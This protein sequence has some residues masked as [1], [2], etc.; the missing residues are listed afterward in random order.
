MNCVKCVNSFFLLKSV[1]ALC[2]ESVEVH[3]YIT[4]VNSL[5]PLDSTI[6]K[7]A[8]HFVLPSS[9]CVRA[10]RGKDLTLLDLVGVSWCLQLGLEQNLS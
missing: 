5:L 10:E 9:C 6:F 8:P 7:G 1:L 2:V 4:G 3:L